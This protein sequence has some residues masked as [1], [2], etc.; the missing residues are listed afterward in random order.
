MK[1]IASLPWSITALASAT[2][3]VL[4]ILTLLT[5]RRATTPPARLSLKDSTAIQLLAIRRAGYYCDPKSL[6]T[7]ML[8]VSTQ[9]NA[10]Y[11]TQFL[12]PTPPPKPKPPTSR[13]VE[14]LFQGVFE[15]SNGAVEAL[16][17][18]PDGPVY[19]KN[20]A[21]LLSDW[22]IESISLKQLILTNRARQT[23]IFFFSQ[24][25]TLEVPVP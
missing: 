4:L 24:K 20:G 2:L 7:R 10:F 25:G 16:V 3:A 11:T 9:T 17:K 15:S 14:V 8:S 13:Q 6:T 19:L 21:V 22:T 23:N 1:P 5:F 12:P 18:L